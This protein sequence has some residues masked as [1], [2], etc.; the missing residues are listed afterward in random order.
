LRNVA[1]PYDLRVRTLVATVVLAALAGCG[2]NNGAESRVDRCVERLL[3]NAEG[4]ESGAAR[5]YARRTYCGPFASRGWVYE[6]GALS[7][8]AQTWLVEGGME[9][10]E[11]AGEDGQSVTIPCEDE[12]R[13]INC[14]M[15]RHVRRG[16]VRQ[17]LAQRPDLECEDGTPVEQLGVP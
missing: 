5:D 8:D 16:E 14:A 3:T 9:I 10:C 1:D 17:Y 15:L 12:S 13:A 11:T 7:I 4:G 2:S 6:D